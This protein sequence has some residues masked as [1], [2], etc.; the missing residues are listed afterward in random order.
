MV[1]FKFFAR[2]NFS[3]TIFQFPV[4]ETFHEAYLEPKFPFVFSN[5]WISLLRF[6]KSKKKKKKKKINNRISLIL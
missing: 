4:L 6:S 1:V 3:Q 5:R 2:K